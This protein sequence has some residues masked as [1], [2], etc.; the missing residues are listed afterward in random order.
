MGEEPLGAFITSLLELKLDP[1]TTFKWQKTS[2][3][4]AKVP[5]YNDLLEFLNLRAQASETLPLETRKCPKREPKKQFINTKP[6]ASFVAHATEPIMSCVLCK[7]ERHPLYACSRFKSFPHDKML[8]TVRS[9]NLCLNC[10]S[11]VICLRIAT[12]STV[13]GSVRS[14]IIPCSTLR[15]KRPPHP[16]TFYLQK[17]NHICLLCHPLLPATLKLDLPTHC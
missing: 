5:H 13:A 4:S 12:A 11:Q 1:S 7:H 3:D 9:N 10:L 2:Q 6:I 15:S 14:H 17:S 8:F 16:T